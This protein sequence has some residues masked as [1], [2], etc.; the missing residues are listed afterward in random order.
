MKKIRRDGNQQAV[1]IKAAKKWTTKGYAGSHEQ[2]NLPDRIIGP[3][4]TLAKEARQLYC[5]M[6][7]NSNLNLVTLAQTNG[8]LAASILTPGRSCTRM[9]GMGEVI[10][11][12]QCK[13]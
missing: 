11:L 1:K 4:N 9:T 7:T 13:V 5:S 8:L 12:Q 3:E 2:K 6:T 10:L